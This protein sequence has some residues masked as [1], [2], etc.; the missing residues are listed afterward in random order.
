MN[1]FDEFKRFHWGYDD[2]KVIKV[3]NPR[4]PKQNKNEVPRFTGIGR[5]LE[6]R[7]NTS[8]QS[9]LDSLKNNKKPNYDIAITLK[10]SSINDSY[11]VYDKD[12]K[13]ERIYLSI[14]QKDKIKSKEIYRNFTR[15]FLFDQQIKLPMKMNDL[16]YLL[17][18][19]GFKGKHLVYDYENVNVVPIG[20]V[21][22]VLY[23]TLKNGHGLSNYIHAF[24]EPYKSNEKWSMPPLLAVDDLGSFWLI[25][26]NYRC[27]P[28]GIIN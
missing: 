18:E 1:S 5:L 9:V 17:R 21:T 16:V 19:F 11:I 6:L 22:D 25:G 8:A 12:M 15:N 24:G 27:V 7:I 23:K 28:A 20:F 3:N 13:N 14:P 10:G 4:I 26:G 2:T